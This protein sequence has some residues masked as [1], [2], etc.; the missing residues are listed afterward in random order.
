SRRWH[1]HSSCGHYRGVLNP[2]LDNGRG[3]IEEMSAKDVA[4]MVVEM[5]EDVAMALMATTITMVDIV[6][7]DAAVDATME[8]A[9]D[10]VEVRV[11]VSRAPAVT[12]MSTPLSYLMMKDLCQRSKEE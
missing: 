5:V 11:P 2:Y 7:V 9:V 3:N 4:A 1:D 8:A 12:R 6:M 10:V